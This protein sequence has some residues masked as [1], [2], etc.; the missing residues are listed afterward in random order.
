MLLFCHQ[1]KTRKQPGSTWNF[2]QSSIKVSRGGFIPYFK[3]NANHFLLLH[4][5]RRMSQPSGQV[6]KH[7]VDSHISP[8]EFTPRIHP[9]IFLWSPKG[10]ISPEYFLDF[11]SNLYIPPWLRKSFKFMTLRWLENTF[12]SQKI[13]SVHFYSYPQAKLSPRSISSLLQTEG[14]YPFPLRQSVLKTY[15]SPTKRGR[16]M[17]LKIWPKLKLQGYW[18]QVL[19]NPTICNLKIYRL[20]CCAIYNLDS[21]M[22]KYEC[23]LT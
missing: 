18:S 10:F 12:L 6:G 5:F 17:G 23:S 4:L 22:L 1:K 16:T 11:F 20:F 9:L 19:I 21:S 14:N 8:S 3:I 2:L 13:E 15:F 7:I